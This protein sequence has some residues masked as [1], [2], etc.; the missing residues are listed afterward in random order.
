MASHAAYRR[1][2]KESATI[3]ANP[4]PFIV[5]RPLESNI[6]EWHYIVR[7]PPETPYEGGE[8]HGKLIFPDNYPFKPP[9][10][11]MLTPNGRFQIDFRL[12]LT[13]SDYHPNTWNPAWSVSTILTGLLSFM[14]EET[15]TTGS[16]KTSLAERRL[17]A[18]KSHAF[19][20]N[21]SKFAA[22]FPEYC[23]PEPLPLPNMPGLKPAVAVSPAAPPNSSSTSL[24]SAFTLPPPSQA[25][26]ASSTSAPQ[27]SL[28]E[29]ISSNATASTV[30]A[31]SQ[32]RQ[33]TDAARGGDAGS[34]STSLAPPHGAQTRRAAV[35]LV[36]Q[37]WQSVRSNVIV[38][39]LLA[40]L[41]YLVFLK[42]L[43]RLE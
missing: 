39:L 2:A 26:P 40:L 43:S 14:L 22:V 34:S 28:P 29:I 23:T 4:P 21:N 13:M 27:S 20:L 12:C 37:A 7:G 17:L 15:P 42:V 9:A 36:D 6:L 5:A 19:N 24:S 8:Y 3:A 31:K 16:I 32:L 33:R 25:T 10:I 38:L 18:K 41:S 1:L 11:K 30:G 35:G